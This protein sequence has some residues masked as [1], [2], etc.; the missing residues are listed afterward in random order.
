MKTGVEGMA[1][2][3]KIGKKRMIRGAAG[4]A[5]FA[6]LGLATAVGCGKP[7]PAE[8]APT[9]SGIRGDGD[10]AELRGYAAFGTQCVSGFNTDPKAI[11]LEL[12]SCPINLKVVEMS[13][14]LQPLYMQADCKTKVLTIRSQDRRIDANWELMPDGSFYITQDGLSAKL[15]D[16]GSGMGEC[17]TPLSMDL[18]GKVECNAASPDRAKI[19]LETVMW[20][21]NAGT[22]TAPLPGAKCRA[23]PPPSEKKCYFHA[24]TTLNQCS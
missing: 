18:W 11:R 23:L 24:T 20:L 10:M 3:G 8:P 6:L 9:Q 16:D 21:N 4:A 19:H 7:G 17:V 15:K 2:S 14:P 13:E 5:L 1:T 12:W 22:A